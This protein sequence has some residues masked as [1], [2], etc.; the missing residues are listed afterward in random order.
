MNHD[1][2]ECFRFA[3][4]LTVFNTKIEKIGFS[5]QLI[6]QTHFL[7]GYGLIIRC[8]GGFEP[9]HLT[10]ILGPPPDV[11]LHSLLSFFVFLSVSYNRDSHVHR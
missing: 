1:Q 7:P 3:I 10:R 9:L 11:Y 8:S 2:C 4:D 6:V 5:Y